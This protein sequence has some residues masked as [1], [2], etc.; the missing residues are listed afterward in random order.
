MEVTRLAVAVMVGL[1]ASLA[2]A[3]AADEIRAPLGYQIGPG[4][5]LEVSVWKNEQVSRKVLVRP[6]GQISLPLLND[7]QA[8]GSTPM[9]LR[10]RLA[11]L[12]V[13][14]IPSPEVSVIVE[15][16]ASAGVSVI[17]EVKEPGRFP[18]QGRLTVLDAIALAKGFTEFA[19][20]G[21]VTILR[22]SPSEKARIEFDY[23]SAISES[24]AAENIELR[25]G[26]I[27]VVP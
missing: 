19:S 22:S 26:D 18:L 2:V 15:A 4:D 14:F 1:F 3:G 21:D 7:V 13:E 24:G 10:E 17:G 5:L 20:R 23:K 11:K 16:V 9:E 12:L 25:P 8:A 27:V 6:D